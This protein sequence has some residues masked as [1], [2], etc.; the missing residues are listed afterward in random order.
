MKR[1]R[2][3]L[4]T[5]PIRALRKHAYWVYIP[6]ALVFASIGQPILGIFALVNFSFFFLQSTAQM[7]VS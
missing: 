5:R 2:R 3:I 6:A 4:N 1:L 7:G